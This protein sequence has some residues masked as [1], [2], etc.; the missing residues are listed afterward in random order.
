[1]GSSDTTNAIS[2][3]EQILKY[4]R[5]PINIQYRQ[6]YCLSSVKGNYNFLKSLLL[7]LCVD[8]SLASSILNRSKI[9]LI[10]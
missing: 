10:Y 3:L 6:F 5:L 7:E 1:M 9:S 8:T 2:G 4:R